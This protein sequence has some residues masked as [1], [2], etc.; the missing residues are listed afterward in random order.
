MGMG[1]KRRRQ[2]LQKRADDGRRGV[3]LIRAD[4]V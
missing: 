3:I 2:E 4:G 1:V